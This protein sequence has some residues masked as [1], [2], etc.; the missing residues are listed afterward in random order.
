MRKL[1]N[2]W[3]ERLISDATST[4]VIQD[5]SVVPPGEIW[6]LKR[7][8][9]RND[10]TSGSDVLVSIVT[11]GYEHVVYYA[12]D[13]VSGEWTSVNLEIYLREGEFLRLDWTSVVSGDRLTAHLTGERLHGQSFR[14]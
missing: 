9:L 13:L 8:A 10:T 3:R 6:Y 11:A 1:E 5:S 2:L 4:E 14:D 12:K 7:L